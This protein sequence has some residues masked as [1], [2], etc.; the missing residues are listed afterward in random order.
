MP[1]KVRD[2]VV[3]IT[4]A[5]SGIG[6]ATAL[7]FARRGASVVLAARREQALHAVR[8]DCERLGGRALAAPTD[9]TDE[10]AVQELARHAVEQFGRLDVWVNNAAVTLFARF[11]EMPIEACRRVIETNLFG[12]IYGARA[13][14]PY[15]R[16]QG[17]GVLINV[18]S[19]AGRVGQPYTSAY[20]TTKWGIRGLS[21]CLRQ[22]LLLDA[23]HDIHVCTVLPASI[24]TPIFQQGANYTGRAVKPMAPVYAAEQVACTIVRLAE[25]PRR[26][27]LVG[28][29]GRLLSY[30]HTV[31]PGV[32]E[33]I[34]ARQV[35]A[36]H[37]QDAPAPLS[38]GNLFEPL[39]QWASVSGGWKAAGRAR[40]RRMAAAALPALAPAVL[41]WLW[42]RPRRARQ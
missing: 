14:V 36:E 18:A 3:A 30:L 39:P 10:A 40:V 6:R 28:R 21:E 4:G 38:A 26:E 42:S 5:S 29:A 9:V 12:Y 31:A 11:E 32:V 25:Q 1:R 24:D 7:A 8:A 19:I 13:A 37:F 34:L 35:E 16:E 27:A 22:E 17:S 33:R 23:P 41:V 20:V 2:A 15:F